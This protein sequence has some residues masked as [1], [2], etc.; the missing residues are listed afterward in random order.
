MEK[1]RLI[2]VLEAILGL[3]SDRVG[4]GRYKCTEESRGEGS[5]GAR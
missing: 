3:G 4:K 2:A 5:V 1:L